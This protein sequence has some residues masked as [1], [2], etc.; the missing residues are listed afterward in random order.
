MPPTLEIEAVL[1]LPERKGRAY[2]ASTTNFDV[3]CMWPGAGTHVARDPHRSRADGDK[4]T[5]RRVQLK[6]IYRSVGRTAGLLVYQD[7][8][9]FIYLGRTFAAATTGQPQIEFRQEE[10]G[11]QSVGTVI[12]ASPVSATIYLR[13]M[14]TGNLYQAFYSYDNVIFL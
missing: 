3:G 6:Y 5:E 10:G 11:A 4:P 14:R 13:L 12:E 9:Q 2:A 1:T 8:D 7:E